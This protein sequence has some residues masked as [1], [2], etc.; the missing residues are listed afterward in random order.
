MFNFKS[1][2]LLGHETWTVEEKTLTLDNYRAKL[3]Q[4]N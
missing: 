2:F 4:H 3:L 1:C